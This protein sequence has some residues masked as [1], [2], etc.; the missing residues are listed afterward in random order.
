VL[1]GCDAETLEQVVTELDHLRRSDFCI[2]GRR[3]P[4]RV[5]GNTEARNEPAGKKRPA[6]RV[7]RRRAPGSLRR[8]TDEPASLFAPRLPDRRAG[9]QRKWIKFGHNL[10]KIEPG[11][12]HSVRR[13]VSTS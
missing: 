2:A 6:Q 5:S 10:L 9:A 8:S 4:K 1:T 11:A 13:I 7:V 12:H 3:G